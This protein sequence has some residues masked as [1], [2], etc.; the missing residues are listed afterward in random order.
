[1][2]RHCH[3][4]NGNT[5]LAQQIR[6]G[7]K[8]AREIPA[9]YPSLP[10]PVSYSYSLSEHSL[11]KENKPHIQTAGCLCNRQFQIHGAHQ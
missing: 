11:H 2:R 1:M 10:V 8:Q 6:S 3:H 9:R 4:S 7:I 5:L